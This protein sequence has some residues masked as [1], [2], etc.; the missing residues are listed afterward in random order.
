MI[1]PV[2]AVL[3]LSAL[4]PLALVAVLALS[5]FTL[6]LAAWLGALG[7]LMLLG[8]VAFTTVAWCLGM[9]ALIGVLAPA[10][11]LLLTRPVLR[12][13]KALELLPSISQTERDALD[14]GS[15]WVDGELFGGAPDT[16]RLLTE[17]WPGLSPDEQAFLD[18]PVAEVCA[19]TD[20][21]QVQRQGDLP[22]E[23]W[24]AL[25]RHGFFGL[26]IPKSYGGL[27]FSPSANSAIV[28]RLSSRSTP[29]GVTVMVPNS[30]GPAELLVHYGT[31]AQKDHWLPLLARGEAMPAFALTEPGAGSDAGSI[32]ARGVVFQGDDGRLMLRLDWDKRYI[33]LAAVSTVLGLAFQL[34]D[35]DGLLGGER[36]R[37]ITCALIPS[38][39]P[40]VVLG[41]RHDP[42]GIAFFNCPTQGHGVEVCLE[43]AVFGGL[44]GVGRGWRMLMECLAAGR[45]ISL[46]A[47]ATAVAQ[48]SARVAGAYA[49]VRRQFG[50]PIGRF[51][52]IEE[53]LAR[54]A[55]TAWLLEAA[56]RYTNG[57]LDGGAKPAVVT[58]MAKYNFTEL[59]RRS[60]TDAMDVVAG[61]GISRGPRNL[62]AHAYQGAPISI[63]VEGANILT[64]CLVVFG[65][66]AIRCH[67]WVQQE[68]DA[69]ES[70]DIV[71][72]DR[73]FWGH[74]K[75]VLRNGARS[76]LLSASRGRLAGSPVDGPGARHWR[77]LSWASASFAFQADLAMATLGGSLKRRETVAGRFADIFSWMYLGTAAL[78]RFEAE[79]RRPEDIPLLDWSMELAF[80]RMQES[81]DGLFRN[82]GVS[83]LEWLLAGPVLLWSRLNPLGLGPDD[84][85]AAKVARSIGVPG[86]QRDRITPMVYLPD[87]VS[88]ALGR[89]E[90]AHVLCVEADGTIRR[91]KDAIRKGLLPRRPPVELL[92]QAREAGVL[93]EADVAQVREAEAAR[94]DLI[95][96]DSFTLEEYLG[97][98]AEQTSRPSDLP[99]REGVGP[100]L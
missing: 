63:T 77:R 2:L 68:I 92:D 6:P 87:D 78:R 89:L 51:E 67:P 91:I 82:L 62:L 11:R 47:S 35:P 59:A 94:T 10:R 30:L 1:T 75:H 45:G 18:G 48:L 100:R 80:A 56:R 43:D 64:R 46:P 69:A 44:D 25:R 49:A 79:G 57:G 23:V 99:Q 72:F 54:I 3:P 39:T 95:Q 74:V 71:S 70:G 13:M 98:A 26:I 42:M 37:G 88:E 8:G 52:G 20:D 81:F 55:G 29:L 65:Q 19:L 15:V 33:T 22:R 60:V 76:L 24:D 27:G 84:E 14:A 86:E 12:A 73:A 4:L 16:A 7:A 83:G 5:W 17:A 53:P 21:W 61:A 34:E 50:V 66:G 36:Q 40:G 31:D 38:D 93:S 96:V 85:L 32:R 41:R 97:R 28:A 9:A 90:R 58:A